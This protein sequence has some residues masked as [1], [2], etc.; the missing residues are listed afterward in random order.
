MRLGMLSASRPWGCH[1]SVRGFSVTTTRAQTAQ[2]LLSCRARTCLEMAY[3]T[4]SSFQLG[5]FRA[6]VWTR[7]LGL[8]QAG[9]C[10]SRV[11]RAGAPV[12][13]RPRVVQSLF[14]FAKFSSESRLRQ[15]Q[16]PSNSPERQN[17]RWEVG[18]SQGP[19][20]EPTSGLQTAQGT[21]LL[22]DKVK[23]L[24]FDNI[25]S[26]AQLKLSCWSHGCFK[27]RWYKEELFIDYHLN[28]HL[29]KKLAYLFK[30]GVFS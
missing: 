1:T 28:W 21:L 11:W 8:A 19:I 30:T 5:H 6:R 22:T 7:V 26:K 27:L 2:E 15:L 25:L 12:S 3:S 29:P 23:D 20:A 18:T 17:Q 4:E 13:P 10:R 14:T 9:K 24:T 16:S